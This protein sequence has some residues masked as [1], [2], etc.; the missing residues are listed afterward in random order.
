MSK[1]GN[2]KDKHDPETIVLVV[3]IINLISALVDLISNILD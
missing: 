1:K 2:K 3:A